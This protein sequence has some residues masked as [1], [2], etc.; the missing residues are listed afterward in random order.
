MNLERIYVHSIC[1]SLSEIAQTEYVRHL[2]NGRLCSRSLEYAEWKCFTLLFCKEQQRNEQII[3]AHAYT[4]IVLIAV[5]VV[6]CLMGNLSKTRLQRQRDRHQKRLLS[7]PVTVNAHYKYLYIFL[8]SSA[9]LAC[10]TMVPQHLL[11]QLRRTKER[12]YARAN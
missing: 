4:A 6:V 5:A 1:L 8:P 11:D 10:V 12:P 7:R 3:T 2:N 9:K